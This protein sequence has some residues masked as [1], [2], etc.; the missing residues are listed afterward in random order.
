MK[1]WVKKP[2]DI[3]S[4]W[5]SSQRWKTLRDSVF[6]TDPL[7]RLC[8]SIA[9]HIHHIEM[10]FDKFWER[11]NLVPICESCHIKTHE[12]YIRLGNAQGAKILFKTR[13]YTGGVNG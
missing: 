10:D 5:R 13:N 9:D 1:A 4:K 7:C 2:D 8:G 6:A 12:S 3:K 11:D